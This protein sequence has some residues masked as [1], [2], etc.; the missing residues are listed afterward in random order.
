MTTS[1]LKW[2]GQALAD[3]L[4]R[5]A[6]VFGLA[7]SQRHTLDPVPRLPHEAEFLPA[8]LALQ[9]TPLS[10]AP[11]VAMW[12][13]VAFVAL[14][15]GWATVGRIDVVATASGKVVAQVGSKVVQPI[16]TATVR[17]ILVQEG[18]TVHAGQV[19]I[20]LD[21]SV[22]QAD[23]TRLAGELADAR[24]QAVRAQALLAAIDSGQAPRLAG[25]VS[26][27][28]D[29]LQAAQR[30]LTSQHQE[31]LARQ[32]RIDAELARAD[33][34]RQSTV[35]AV[36]KLE[37]TL[38]MAERRAQDFKDLADENFISRHGYQDRE[39]ARVEK[40]ADLATLRSRLAEIDAGRR[41]TVDQ[42]HEL[43]TQTRR[44]ALDS[45]NEG[46]QRAASLEQELAKADSHGRQMQL[47]APVDGTVQQLAVRTVGGVVT[48]AQPLMVIVPTHE[49]LEVEAMVENKDIGFVRV[50]Q[51][52][53]VKVETF[54]YT[55]Y[56]TVP[57]VITSVSHDAISDDKRGLIYATRVRLDRK[58]LDIDGVDVALTPGMAVTVEAKLGT[59]RVMDYFLSPFQRAV[60]ES[61]RER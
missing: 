9:E 48:P 14:A 42:K 40:T 25:G 12:S 33:A 41:A 26:L 36:R 11:R 13:I 3:L 59:R 53:V 7:W 30:L 4:R 46:T 34:E 52:A 29:R 56:G 28:A 60:G 5:Y 23:R 20:E 8:A 45:V 32:R 55:R 21:A 22:A 1:T 35:E 61:L 16:E 43:A 6:A 39:Q 31:Y 54:Q 2:R 24:L 17:A 19:L 50:G 49:T 27:P 18:Q 57:G 10:P 47:T 51:E 37:A 44:T 58:S 38:P 15:L